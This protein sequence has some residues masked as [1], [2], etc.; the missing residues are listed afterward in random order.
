MIRTSCLLCSRCRLC[1]NNLPGL[2]Y[3]SQQTLLN[4]Q[5][6][7]SNNYCNNVGDTVKVPASVD[8]ADT[9]FNEIYRWG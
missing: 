7:L 1:F 6:L 4:R 9:T 2:K 5:V 3:I 8:H